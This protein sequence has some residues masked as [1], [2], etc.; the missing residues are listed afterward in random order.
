M[1]V[2]ISGGAG[3]VG[4]NI[5]EALLR[6]GEHVVVVGLEAPPDAALAQFAHL[7]GRL[8]AEVADVTDTEHFTRLLRRHAVD[9]L[10]PFAAITSGPGRESE[11]P[12]RVITTNLLGFVGQL[13]AARDTGVRRVIIP[14][15][16]AVYGESFYA[17]DALSEDGT[18]CVPASIYGVTK[19]AVERSGLRLGALW[20][21]D[22]IAA[23]IGAVF[24]PWEHDTGL[25]DSLSPYW[26]VAD[27][28]RRGREAVLPTV[29]PSYGFIYARDAA[30]GLLHLLDLPSPAHRVF[31]VATDQ[32]WGPALADWCAALP[33]LKWR[34]SD[35]A[36]A[37]TVRLVD[38][39]PRGRMAIERIAGTGWIPRYGPA[40]AFADY[41]R[42]LSSRPS[43]AEETSVT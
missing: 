30:A 22:V 17:H 4:L 14:S 16:A 9:R 36:A 42:W 41:A 6:R 1:T 11:M 31:N 33:G 20:D 2:L 40:T 12:E 26:Q 8:V 3:F 25:R 5:A 37:Q 27:L 7:P 19:Y 15:S 13:R 28:F 39:R 29:L 10:F 35:D 43:V 32:D 38:T 18:P 34:Q 23:R 24:G 21:V